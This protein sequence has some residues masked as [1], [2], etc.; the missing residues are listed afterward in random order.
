MTI[1]HYRDDTPD[2]EPRRMRPSRILQALSPELAS[3]D[4]PDAKAGDLMFSSRIAA[5]STSPV[6]LARRRR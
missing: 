6:F 3:G 1:E 5:R 2:L 4:W